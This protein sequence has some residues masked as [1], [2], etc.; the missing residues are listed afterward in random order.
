MSQSITGNLKILDAQNKTRLLLEGNDGGESYI[1]VYNKAGKQTFSFAGDRGFTVIG[2]NGVGGALKILDGENNVQLELE[3]SSGALVLG[4]TL[5][6]GNGKNNG[7]LGINDAS[8]NR[9]IRME[10][11][12][13]GIELGREGL[14]GA[15]TILNEKKN[16]AVL[17]RSVNNKGLLRIGAPTFGGTLLVSGANGNDNIEMDGEGIVRMKGLS[18]LNFYNPQNKESISIDGRYADINLGGNGNDGDIVIRNKNG[19]EMIHLD[20]DACNISIKNKN[21][22]EGI[23]LDG[24]AGDIKLYGA[25]CAENFEVVAP[26]EPGTVMCLEEEERLR[27]CNTAYDKKVAGVI[28]GAGRYRPGVLLGH[29]PGA[30][31]AI[32]QPLALV[33]RVMCK[34]DADIAPVA[35]GDLLTTSPSLGYAM[36]AGDLACAPGAILG[37]SLTSLPSGKGLIPIIV[38]LQ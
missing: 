4:R 17:M 8:G 34:V 11:E 3:K 25:D 24:N 30:S 28:S 12:M 13:A 16:Y 7:F 36:K 23:L 33:G 2:G 18:V 38:T 6:I 32:K 15:L 31:D 5:V 35:A 26:V 19:V 27:P 22:A 1:I 37:K 10:G 9:T 20:G 14:G 21:G 29:D